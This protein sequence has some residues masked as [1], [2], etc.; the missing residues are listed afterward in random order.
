MELLK[1]FKSSPISR[2]Y[3]RDSGRSVSLSVPWG[4]KQMGTSH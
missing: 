2:K 3:A 1:G 4:M